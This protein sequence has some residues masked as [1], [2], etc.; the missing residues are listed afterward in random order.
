MRGWVRH[1]PCHSQKRIIPGNKDSKAHQWLNGAHIQNAWL[2]LCRLW[3]L[4]AAMLCCYSCTVVKFS[5]IVRVCIF[6]FWLSQFLCRVYCTTDSWR[7]CKCSPQPQKHARIHGTM[8]R[9][10]NKDIGSL[11]CLFLSMCVPLNCIYFSWSQVTQST[12]FFNQLSQH[13]KPTEHLQSSNL[14]LFSL[15][16]PS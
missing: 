8:A 11:G 9:E 7:G 12:N 16:D 4:K 6:L 1:I 5:W 3:P 2:S 14:N 10:N 15:S 13:Q